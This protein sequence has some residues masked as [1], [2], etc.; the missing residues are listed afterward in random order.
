MVSIRAA[1][2]KSRKRIREGFRE[3]VPSSISVQRSIGMEEP[4]QAGTVFSTMRLAGEGRV[5]RL[6]RTSR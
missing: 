3:L 4:A 6:I 1:G 2:R 5:S